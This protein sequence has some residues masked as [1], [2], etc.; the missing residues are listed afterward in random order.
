MATRRT[1]IPLASGLEGNNNNNNGLASRADSQTMLKPAASA[2]ADPTDSSLAAPAPSPAATGSSVPSTPLDRPGGPRVGTDTLLA[3]AMNQLGSVPLSASPRTV[4]EHLTVFGSQ[5]DDDDDDASTATPG[6]QDLEHEN[7]QRA[8]STGTGTSKMQELHLDANALSIGTGSGAAGG[9]AASPEKTAVGGGGGGSSSSAAPDNQELHALTVKKGAF[10]KATASIMANLRV[11]KHLWDSS[12]SAKPLSRGDVENPLE[13]MHQSLH[14]MLWNVPHVNVLRAE[15]LQSLNVMIREYALDDIVMERGMEIQHVYALISGTV[16]VYDNR[17]MRHL[18]K[19]VGSINAPNLFGM[20][21]IV[22]DVPQMFSMRAG[23]RSVMVLIPKKDFLRCIN[24]NRQF[25]HSLTT[26][27]VEHM[28]VFGVFQDFC[29]AVFTTATDVAASDGNVLNLTAIIGA[30]RKLNNVIHPLVNEPE[31]DVGGWLYASRRLPENV[32][33]SLVINLSRA[34][35]AFLAQELRMHVEEGSTTG[36]HSSRAASGDAGS[37]QTTVKYIPTHDR[38]RCSWQIGT[39]GHT[40]VLLRET[41]TD[42]LDFITCMCIHIVESQK[43]RRRLRSS[44]TGVRAIDVLHHGTCRIKQLD[45]RCSDYA[46]EHS[47][48]TDDALA[49]LKL[50]DIEVQGLKRIWPSKCLSTIYEIFMHREEYM[51][52]LDSGTLGR[53]DVDPYVRWALSLRRHMLAQLGLSEVDEIPS[54][55]TIDIISSN[56]HGIKNCLCSSVRKRAHEIEVWAEKNMPAIHNLPWFNRQDLLF[57]TWAKMVSEDVDLRAD[58]RAQLNTD[59][60]TIIEDSVMT[61]LQVDIVELSRLATECVDTELQQSACLFK[62]AHSESARPQRCFL[63][64][65]DFAFGA[66]ADYITHALI[67]AFGRCIRSFNVMGK[68]GALVGK[69]GDIQLPTSIVFSKSALGEDTTDENRSCGNEDL[70]AQ[71]L[72]ELAGPQIDV[73]VGPVLTIPGTLLQNER[74]LRFYRTVIGCVGLEME[75]T[76]FARQLEEAIETGLLSPFVRRRFAYNTSDLPLRTQSASLS[77]PMSPTEERP[78]ANAILRAILERIFL[79]CAERQKGVTEEE[80]H[81]CSTRSTSTPNNMNRSPSLSGVVQGGT[82]PGSSVAPT[83]FLGALSG[84]GKK[85]T[86]PPPLQGAAVSA[87]AA[88]SLDRSSSTGSRAGSYTM[89]S[90]N[91]TAVKH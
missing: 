80:L 3:E 64:N 91:R 39:K 82:N 60:F 46:T 10:R 5:G 49:L 45:P 52:T 9:D 72:R 4:N 87:S 59:G 8:G 54:D 21:G 24:S 81:A 22:F 16:E 77:K 71:R 32:A 84:D 15:E 68:A 18:E 53:F 65:M 20:D 89:P 79:D 31:L 28:G 30:Y 6:S 27:I 70:L 43:L 17:N 66:Q 44:Q 67:L 76:Y 63:I 47:K 36:G 13:V 25:A 85:D 90:P 2:A 51:I 33:E 35:P 58:Y 55:V 69:R 62:K 40:F 88:A 7:E 23:E 78:P 48:I 11:S 19:R 12:A 14:K 61:G 38:R 83:V 1:Q 37:G 56:T 26:P 34:L 57:Y 42:V 73:H 41:Y 74:L 75:G 86:L 29:R 50:S